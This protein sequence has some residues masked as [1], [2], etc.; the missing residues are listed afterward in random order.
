MYY[1]KLSKCT[2]SLKTTSDKKKCICSL[3]CW[4]YVL[5]ELLFWSFSLYTV[6]P[7]AAQCHI[8][9]FNTTRTYCRRQL[10]SSLH[11][12]YEKTICPTVTTENDHAHAYFGDKLA[13]ISNFMISQFACLHVLHLWGLLWSLTIRKLFVIL[14]NK[15][16]AKAFVL[17]TCGAAKMRKTMSM[18]LNVLLNTI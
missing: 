4:G 15:V 8:I 2:I 17:L 3:W 5:F 11:F 16:T 18:E 1:K 6:K 10:I 7:V 12:E 13:L 9:I 14:S